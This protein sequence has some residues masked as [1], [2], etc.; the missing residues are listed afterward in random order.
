MEVS[1]YMH[2]AKYLRGQPGGEVEL[3]FAELERI[4]G[5]PLPRSA[6]ELRVWWSND[7]THSQAR[8][9]WLAAGWRVES[10]NLSEGRVAFKK[11]G[12]PLASSAAK[13]EEVAKF[14]DAVVEAM[15]RRFGAELHVEV[16]LRVPL[17]S[18]GTVERIFDLASADGRIIGEMMLLSGGG[19]A[20]RFPGIS[21][22]VWLLEKI[23]AERKF[24]AFGG[25]PSVP[26]LWLKRYMQLAPK[27]VSF[28]FISLDGRV[29]DLWVPR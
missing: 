18:G 22:N 26:R 13:D 9:G 29:E 17:K 23:E 8:F 4:L 24:I 10:V 28:H 27:D 12:K 6:R 20:S 16:R 2:L 14:T 19:A 5:S 3:S 15:S 21:E 7:G 11:S 1:R 25:D